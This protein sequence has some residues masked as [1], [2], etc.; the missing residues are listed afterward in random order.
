MFRDKIASWDRIV[1][2]IDKYVT[3]S[4]EPKEEEHRVSVRPVAKERP[5]LKPAVTRSRQKN[6]WTLKRNDHMIERVMTGEKP[7]PDCCDMAKQSLGEMTEQFNML[8]SWKSA[9]RKSSM[10]LRNGQFTIG[11]LFWQ[12]RRQEKV[13]MLL[14]SKLFQTRPVPR[15]NLRTFRR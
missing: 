14:E 10:V 13:S 3:E 1:N 2:G 11:F 4:M 7:Y 8:T 12:R 6:G 5:R 9:G 15:N